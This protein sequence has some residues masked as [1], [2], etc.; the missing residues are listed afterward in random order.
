MSYTVDETIKEIAVKHGVSVGRDDPILIM[1]T[2]HEKLIEK[3]NKAQQL[4]LDEFKSEIEQISSQWK[5]DAKE[6][7]EQVLN[8]ALR[9]CKETMTKS[10]KTYT[11]ES[12][13]ELKNVISD[14]IKEA[15]DLNI[16]AQKNN[17]FT[18]IASTTIL[19]T[20][21]SFAALT[22]AVFY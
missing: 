17:R 3:Q 15:R 18:I 10:I 7:S 5:I 2:M 1:Q 13:T 8:S 22:Y 20:S 11:D 6:K 9:A 16:Q 21:I 14:S 19:L 12:I 4:L